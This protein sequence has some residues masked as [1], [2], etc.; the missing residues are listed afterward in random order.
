MK[1]ELS[2]KKIGFISKLNGF[3]GELVLAADGE[4]FFD[5]KFLFMNRDGIPVPFFVED[6]FEKG[7]SVIVKLE[8]I[9][10]EEHAL[11]LVKEE[12]FILQK[13][14]NKAEKFSSQDLVGF[15]IIDAVFGDLGPILRIDDLPQQE[16]A[17]CRVKGKE[18]LIPLNDDFIDSID[19]EK[20]QLNVKL[21]D[22]L[23]D[24]YL[25]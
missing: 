18:V 23:I 24:L 21:P 17:L 8:D 22:G 12:V 25:E 6:M 4:D 15:T 9:N 20:K 19:E 16:I 14:K 2:L 5:E 13:K 10:D 3:K 11:L 1:K 7:G